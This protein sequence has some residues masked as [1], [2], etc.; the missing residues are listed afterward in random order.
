MLV[1]VLATESSPFGITVS[2]VV[3]APGYSEMDVSRAFRGA[4]V[5][6]DLSHL[7][8]VGPHRLLDRFI[9][10]LAA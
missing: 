5:E 1:L 10:A 6:D 7:G 9:G 3:P 4:R 2:R 8:A